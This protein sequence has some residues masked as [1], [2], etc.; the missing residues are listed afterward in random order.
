MAAIRLATW[1]FVVS[2]VSLVT[3]EP[4]SAAVVGG[5]SG[6]SIPIPAL[7]YHGQG[8]QVFGPGI[9]WSSTTRLSVFGFTR[10]YGFSSNG[11]WDAA[12]GPMIGTN[13]GT[14]AMTLELSTPV[15][16]IGG[17]VNFAPGDGSPA[18]I[19]VYD[20]S[21]TLIESTTLTFST[22]GADN[23]GQFVGFQEA[24]PSI[25]Y[26]VLQGEYIGLT[27]LKVAAVPEPSTVALTLTGG[28]L[29]GVIGIRRRWIMRSK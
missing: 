24:T 10:V 28:A 8:P 1:C 9:T 23:S 4:V 17:F 3:A 13:S 5:F 2:V 21:Y 29:A 7:N 25:S 11:G 22:G 20:S 18:T 12:L 26:M 27:D 16:A 6:T 14:D 15:S 19:S